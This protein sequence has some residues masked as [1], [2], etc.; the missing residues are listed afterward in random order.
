MIYLNLIILFIFI[1]FIHEYGHYFVAKFFKAEVTD[2]SIG[3]GKPL[4]KFKDKSG[5]VWK[6]APIPL[7]GYVKIK[8]L[9]SIFS[10]KSEVDKGSFQALT[11]FQKICVLLAGSIFNI[12]SAWLALFSIFFFLG[13]VTFLPIIGSVIENTPASLN[14]L[15][16]GDKILEIN[17]YKIKEFIDISK[18]IKNND[19]VN[20]TLERDNKILRKSFN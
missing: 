20:I 6:I 17:N 7:G 11:L 8:G 14:D 19:S 5:T 10:K 12:F 16:T 9:D 1:V 3:F 2:F 4:Y 13:T 18:A 15:R